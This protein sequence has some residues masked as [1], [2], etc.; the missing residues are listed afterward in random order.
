MKTTKRLEAA[1]IKLYNAYH[2]NKLNPED[3]T[4]CA[5]G[6]ILDKNIPEFAKEMNLTMPTDIKFNTDVQLP[7]I[8]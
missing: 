5:V 4:A 7:K 3:C 8:K 1:L 2:N 6:N